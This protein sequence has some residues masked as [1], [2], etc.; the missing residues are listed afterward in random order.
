M[1]ASTASRLSPPRFR[2]PPPSL[3]P[4]TR[5]SRFSPVRAAK[6]APVFGP[7][8]LSALTLLHGYSQMFGFALF[9]GGWSSVC[10]SN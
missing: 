5:R 6:Y 9:L 10:I 3:H 2:A 4:P 1:A 8:T 7:H